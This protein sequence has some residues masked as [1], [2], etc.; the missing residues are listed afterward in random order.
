MQ[1]A[2]R[3]AMQKAEGKQVEEA[4]RK[5]ETYLAEAQRLSHTGS[6]G[7]KPSTGQLIWSEETF[8]IFRYDRNTTPTVELVLQRVHPEDVALVQ[9][10]IERATQDGKG[11]EHAYRLLMPD[12]SIKHVHVVARALDNESVTLEFVGAVIDVTVAKEAEKTLRES[13][14]YLAE[15]QRLSHTGSWAWETHF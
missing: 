15:A 14:A 10:T 7:W 12:G 8:Q 4:L 1:R 11:F 5:N 9:Q 6:F 3:E 13:E 2:L